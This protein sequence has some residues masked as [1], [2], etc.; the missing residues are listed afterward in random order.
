MN[1]MAHS[2][3]HSAAQPPNLEKSGGGPT[4]CGGG[5][6]RWDGGGPPCGA[7]SRPSLSAFICDLR[8][9]RTMSVMSRLLSEGN[10]LHR[11]S[12]HLGS[13]SYTNIQDE[14]REK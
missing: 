10:S 13:I 2:R 7:L 6:R 12:P 14:M 5:G 11:L 3:G 4:M 9:E 8:A 1:G